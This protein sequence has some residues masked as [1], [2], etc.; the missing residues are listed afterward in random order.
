MRRS[1]FWVSII[2]AAAMAF[3]IVACDPRASGTSATIEALNAT[4]IAQA[5]EIAVLKALTNTLPPSPLPCPTPTSDIPHPPTIEMP[6]PKP[7]STVQ[8]P[9]TATPTPLPTATATATFTPTPVPDAIVGE[10]LT[11]LR[12]GPSVGYEIITE[13]ESGTPLEVLGK[14]ADGEWIQV[15]LPGAQEGWMFYL[16]IILNISLDQ[17]P[18]T[19]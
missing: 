8:R 19:G 3:A 12:S 14:S 6:P 2:L 5:D 18:V 16:P 7:V 13:V 11:N 4:I 9:P 1:T 17:I 15:R 10:A